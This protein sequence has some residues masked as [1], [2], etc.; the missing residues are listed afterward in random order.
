MSILSILPKS[1]TQAFRTNSTAIR[2]LSADLIRGVVAVAF[3]GASKP[4]DYYVY[5]NVSRRAIANLIA[6][7]NMSLGFWVNANCIKPERVTCF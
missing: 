7:P 3:D 1:M 2:C 4:S 5:H 6:N